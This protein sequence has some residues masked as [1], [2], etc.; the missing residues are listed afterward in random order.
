MSTWAKNN[1][2]A[3]GH[4]DDHGMIFNG[5]IYTSIFWTVFL[6]TLAKPH[7]YYKNIIS[8]LFNLKFKWRGSDW[9]IYHVLI[10]I[11]LFFVFLLSCKSF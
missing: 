10:L 4:P 7:R 8:F 5:L 11:T 9:K 3:A 2:Q 6:V 1:L